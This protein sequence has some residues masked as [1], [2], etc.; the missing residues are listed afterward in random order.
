M[1]YPSALERFDYGGNESSM[2][3]RKISLHSH[4]HVFVREIICKKELNLVY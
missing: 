1:P 3:F 4:K 2:N